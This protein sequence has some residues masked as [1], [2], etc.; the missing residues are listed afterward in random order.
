MTHGYFHEELKSISF[1]GAE[2]FS[3]MQN[4]MDKLRQDTPDTIAGLKVVKIRDYSKG[5]EIEGKKENVLRIEFSDDGHNRVTI[6]P[7]G[8]EPKIKIYAQT[9]EDVVSDLQEAK[10][11]ALNRSSSLC[12]ALMEMVNNT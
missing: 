3:S 12:E 5:E 10:T 9:H 6:R 2:G 11:Q 1:P 7:S 8:T 4:F